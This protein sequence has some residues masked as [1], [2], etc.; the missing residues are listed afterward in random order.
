MI[1]QTT[2][3]NQKPTTDKEKGAQIK[4]KRKPANNERSKGE[5]NKRTTKTIKKQ[6]TKWQYRHTYQ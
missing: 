1:I 6:L 3:I 5:R 2:Y 4:H